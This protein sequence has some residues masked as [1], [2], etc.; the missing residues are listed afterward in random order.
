MKK[1]KISEQIEKLT[2]INFIICI[3]ILVLEFLINRFNILYIIAIYPLY[4]C[5][6]LIL[7]YSKIVLFAENNINNNDIS[8]EE[9]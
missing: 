4:F 2:N 8:V 5:K 7:G 9:K 3:V 6:K 1:E